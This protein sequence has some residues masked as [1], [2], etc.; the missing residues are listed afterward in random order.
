MLGLAE[1]IKAGARCSFAAAWISLQMR[2]RLARRT[3]AKF[4]LSARPDQTRPGQARLGQDS[5]QPLVHELEAHAAASFSAPCPVC[6]EQQR[7]Q[8]NSFLNDDRPPA[9][10]RRRGIQS[11]IPWPR[12]SGRNHGSTIPSR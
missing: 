10:S 4:T 1:G 2:M 7:V 12:V 8:R 9:T 5:T 6:E 11:G 3:R